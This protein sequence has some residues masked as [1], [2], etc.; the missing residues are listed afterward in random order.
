MFE[1]IHFVEIHTMAL[2]VKTI[3]KFIN[4]LVK[5]NDLKAWVHTLVKLGAM[6]VC[7]NL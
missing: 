3:Q 5:L 4:K 1:L 7:Y 6:C 2:G